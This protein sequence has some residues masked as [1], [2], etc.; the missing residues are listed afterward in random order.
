[1]GTGIPLAVGLETMCIIPWQKICLN[2]AHVL[3]F[4]QETE[5]KALG[6]INIA[7]EISKQPNVKAE[8]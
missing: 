8:V 1:M 7:E 3:R 5:I 2:F 6:L 4:L